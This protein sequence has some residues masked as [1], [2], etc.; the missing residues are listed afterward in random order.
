MI[1]TTTQ[2]VVLSTSRSLN[3]SIS[4]QTRENVSR[5][6]TACP[7][8]L[9]ERLRQLDTEWDVERTICTWTGLALVG[10]VLLTSALGPEWL[11]VPFLFATFLLLHGL[12]GWSPLLPLIRKM[13]YR[14][15]QEIAQERYALKAIR[16]DFQ[17]L[18]L[19]ATPQDREDLSRLEGEGGN[20]APDPE[21]DPC[22]E[23]VEEAIHAAKS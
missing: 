16:G 11:V 7:Q 18:A 1:P 13:G 3:D 8:L 15:A 21:P 14:T 10:A 4:E 20:A 9:E 2:R 22:L 19:V 23:L 6:A 17:K 12:V 5:Y